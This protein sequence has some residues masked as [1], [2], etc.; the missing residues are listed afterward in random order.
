[1]D[2]K[3]EARVVRLEKL[4]KRK[5]MK[6]ESYDSSFV[7]DIDYLLQGLENA[8]ENHLASEYTDVSPEFDDWVAKATI[9]LKKLKQLA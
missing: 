9:A 6:N 3:L 4:L 5:S 1:M 2:K 7:E 8:V